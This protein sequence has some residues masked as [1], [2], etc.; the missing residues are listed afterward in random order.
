MIRALDDA[1]ITQMIEALSE[2]APAAALRL[3][4]ELAGRLDLE[5]E[6][7]ER[8]TTM[9]TNLGAPPAGTGTRRPP[10]PTQVA[11]LVDASSRVV[12]VASRKLPGERRW[13]R[14]A[15]LIHPAGHIEDCL[16][17][18][19]APRTPNGEDA[20]AAPLIASLVTDGYRVASTELDHARTVVATAA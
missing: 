3:S 15:V 17:E 16:H 20:D 1:A 9:T 7:R 6:I 13:R 14:W 19:A 11:V 4:A 18:E 2:A 10:R 12:V 5:L 8:I